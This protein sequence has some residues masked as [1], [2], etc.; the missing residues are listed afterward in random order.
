MSGERDLTSTY[1]FLDGIDLFHIPGLDIKVAISK[2]PSKASLAESYME[3]ICS[4]NGIAKLPLKSGEILLLSA[5]AWEIFTVKNPYK[6]GSPSDAAYLAKYEAEGLRLLLQY[7]KPRQT[8]SHHLHLETEETFAPIFGDL[9]IWHNQS[10]VIKVVTKTIVG[11]R[12]SHIGFT[13]DRPAVTLVVQEGPNFEHQY[14]PRSNI[15]FLIA[16]AKL[17][18]KTA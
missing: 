4:P 17:L 12:E 18:D 10:Q 6:T 11:P 7:L 16:K 3:L 2:D 5:S 9:F 15:D 8:T 13:I 14:L 1:S